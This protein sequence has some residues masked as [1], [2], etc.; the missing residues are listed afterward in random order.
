MLLFI[1]IMI[2]L[3]YKD[4]GISVVS[5]YNDVLCYYFNNSI[6]GV[7]CCFLVIYRIDSVER[8]GE[9]RRELDG[10]LVLMFFEK[11]R[12]F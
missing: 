11:G 1:E 5:F 10:I 6:N 9:I 3:G 2:E 7:G 12:F 8:N 4:F